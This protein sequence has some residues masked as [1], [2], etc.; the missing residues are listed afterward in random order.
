VLEQDHPNYE[1]ILVDDGST[2]H[3][4]E[5]ISNLIKAAPQVAIRGL[6]QVNQGVAAARNSG[7]LH[8]RGH[9][10]LPLDADDLIDKYT[11]QAAS[12]ILDSQPQTAVVYSDRQDFGDIQA[13]W[14]A[15]KYQLRY[16]KYFNQ[17]SYCCMYRKSVWQALGGY[18]ENIDGFDDW[19]FWI[20]LAA[21]HYQAAYIA[22]PLLQHRRHRGSQ[23]WGILDSYE[24]LFAQIILNN[25]S[26]YSASEL[27]AAQQFIDT[28]KTSSTIALSKRIFVQQ[29]Y[30]KYP[31][32]ATQEHLK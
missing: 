9:Y 19:N 21:N 12:D 30:K 32:L 18:R 27:T 17:F 6:S 14:P 3:T 31:K 25:P 20:G 5:V 11:L 10:I 4:G 22:K 29:Y 28:A 16:L 13:Y 7:I 15:G 24:R 26:V 8:A 23:L 1:I 2:D